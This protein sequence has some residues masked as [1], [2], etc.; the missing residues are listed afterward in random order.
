M[1][2]LP[3]SAE[4]QH[5]KPLLTVEEQIA[6]L[7]S[8]GITFDL[9]GEAEA[10]TILAKQNNYLRITSYRQLFDRQ[11]EGANVGAYINL[12]FGDLAALSS[13][14]RKLRETFLAL[15][16]DV[17]HF[18]KM[19]VLASVED[20]GE[21]GY[22]IVSDFYAGLNH[23]GRNAI[24]GAMHA[25]GGI[26][27]RHDAY[28]GDLIA[29]HLADMP[30]WVFLE[31]IDFGTFVN[32]YLFCANRWEDNVMLQE[33]YALKSVKA[34]RNATAH[35]H[36][37]VNGFTKALT[38]TAYDTPQVITESLNGAAMPRTKTRRAKLGNVRI[39]QMAAS[40][41]CLNALCDSEHALARHASRL[42]DLRSAYEARI[43]R[44]RL[45]SSLVSFFDFLFN[46]VDIWVPQQR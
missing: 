34:L 42:A 38:G 25:R 7:K 1:E 17:E 33:H 30:V 8:K 19:K 41:Y 22:G 45:N 12:D 15:T 13:L 39:A 2:E 32:F 18:A 44:Y 26:G 31:V 9:C 27:E 20:H 40:M 5:E 4:P 43:E 3:E 11:T 21:D 46:L 16:V 14:D 29:H 24:Q 23:A 10:A 6:H 35:N 28:A 37:I 36:C